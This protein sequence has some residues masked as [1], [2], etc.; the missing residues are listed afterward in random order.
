MQMPLKTDTPDGSCN[1]TTMPGL[2]ECIQHAR[3]AS[4]SVIICAHQMLVGQRTQQ[5]R[6]E[7]CARGCVAAVGLIVAVAGVRVAVSALDLHLSMCSAMSRPSRA[8]RR[9]VALSIS[10]L[11]CGWLR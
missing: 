1:L 8:V 9:Q 5:N 2:G 10:C 4:A 11:L 3:R 6:E 7:S